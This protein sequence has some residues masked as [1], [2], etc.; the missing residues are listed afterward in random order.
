[1][2]GAGD[3]DG[4]GLGDILMGAYYDNAA[5]TAAGKGYLMYGGDL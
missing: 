2:A 5:G 1:M 4:D 3:V